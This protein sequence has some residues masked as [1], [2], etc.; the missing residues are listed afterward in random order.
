MF[1]LV[2]RNLLITRVAFVCCRPLASV[3]GVEMGRVGPIVI[4]RAEVVNVVVL[5]ESGDVDVIVDGAILN[6]DG[7][8]KQ[9]VTGGH[10]S[11]LLKWIFL[12]V[13][14][15]SLRHWIWI[16]SVAALVVLLTPLA[17]EI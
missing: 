9:L 13:F 5:E 2:Y 14:P 1:W 7:V 17:T 6:V 15:H 10:G 12:H 3:L 8:L 11:F 4:L 16:S